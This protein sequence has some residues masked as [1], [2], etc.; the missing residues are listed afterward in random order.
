MSK[1]MAFEIFKLKI[2]LSF[3]HYS[4]NFEEQIAENNQFQTCTLSLTTNY[5]CQKYNFM[6]MNKKPSQS[7]QIGKNDYLQRC[8][9]KDDSDES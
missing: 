6:N 1:V 4:V 3:E 5:N 2:R 8:S 7:R 9:F